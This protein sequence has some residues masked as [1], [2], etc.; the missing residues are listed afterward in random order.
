MKTPDPQTALRHGIDLVEIARVRRLIDETPRED[1]LRIFSQRELADAAQGSEP[2]RLAARFAAKEA[3]LKLFPRETALGELEASDFEIISDGYGA[4]RVNCAPRAANVL[5]RHW[6]ADISLSLSHD[7]AHAT[8]IAAA[9]PRR[10]VAPMA[11]RLMY[12]C[13]PIRRRVVM[14]N[15]ERAFGAVLDQQQIVTLA[16]AFYGHL[17]NSLTEFAGNLMPWRRR[18]KVRVENIEAI[19]AA[20]NLGRGVL[21]LSGHFGNWEVALPIAMEN[22]PQWRG[23]FHV[24]RRPLPRWLDGAVTRRMRKSGFGVLPKRGSLQTILDRLAARHAV[25]F[26]MDQHAGARDG[27]L[28]D[29][30][31]S[32]AW[33]F[34]S[35][36]LVALSTRAPVVPVALWR[37]PDG[38]HV[39][40]FEQAL[41]TL[42]G[43][44]TDEAIAANTRQY[45]AAVERIILRHP[46]QW[47]WLHRRW[48]PR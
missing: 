10:L 14:S 48:K 5:A 23:C 24:L 37:E 15:L 4:P 12:H 42:D 8:A 28:V 18:P 16:Q 2:A 25:V 44:S 27:V 40:R 6:L 35:L 26:I 31:G 33:T 34:R 7:G 39:L 17:L 45:N 19:L 11:G 20:Y 9:L 38:S 21:L 46:E 3:C 36:A 1:L 22:F 29:F 47:F 43:A 30:F 41:P 32:P 13:L